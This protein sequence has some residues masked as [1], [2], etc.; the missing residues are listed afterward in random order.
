MPAICRIK[1]RFASWGD[2]ALVMQKYLANL[3]AE[4]GAT[5]FECAHNCLPSIDQELFE[6]VGL[7]RFAYAID[8]FE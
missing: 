6:Q 3:D 4:F 5:W 1:Q 2:A 7:R 8:A